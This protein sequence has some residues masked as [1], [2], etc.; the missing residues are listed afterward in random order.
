MLSAIERGRPPSIDYLNGEV[1]TLAKKHGIATPVNS[2]IV[3]TI[4]AIARG[5]MRSST[6]TLDSVFEATR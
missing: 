5:E 6:D 4:H 3:D 1:V 2:L